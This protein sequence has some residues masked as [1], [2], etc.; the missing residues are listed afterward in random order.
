MNKLSTLGENLHGSEIRRLFATS[1]RPGIISFAG[2]MPDPGSFPAKKVAELLEKLLLDRGDLYLQYGPSS[3][4]TEGIAAAINRMRRRDIITGADEVIMTSGSQQA[5]DLMTRIFIDP[6]DMILVEEP[7]FIG[8]LGTFRNGKARI[9]GVPMDHNGIIPEE[10]VNILANAR[11][12]GYRVK[13]MYLL[14]NFQNPTGLTMSVQRRERVLQIAEDYDFLIFEDD[15]YGELWFTGGLDGVRPIKSLDRNGRVIYTSSFS[16]IISPGIR[17]GWIAA[18][19]WLIERFDMGKQML[20][21]C[22]NPLMQAVAYELCIDGFLDAHIEKLRQI[23][24]SRAQTMLDALTRFMPEGVSWTRPNGGFFIWVTLPEHID[25]LHMLD[26]ALSHDVVYVIGSAF[27]AGSGNNNT[28]RISFC[29]ESEEIIAEG[30][31]RLGDAVKE[32]LV[33]N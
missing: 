10:L 11:K 20:D 13:F 1:M 21:V 7:T 9:E 30:I 29:H 12:N 3:G 33:R 18:S 5:I 31:K 28:L 16:K 23:Y 32:Y 26:K 4:T 25:A 15:P 6:G 17:L 22:T 24:S 19:S 2:G 8:A 14:P 27:Y